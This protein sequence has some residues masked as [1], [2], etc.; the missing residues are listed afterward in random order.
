MFESGDGIAV[1]VILESKCDFILI[2]QITEFLKIEN[3]EAVIMV[4]VRQFLFL[5][6]LSIFRM[7]RIV[8]FVSFFGK[9]HRIIHFLAI[10]FGDS[11][12]EI[13]LNN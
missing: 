12:I 3:F 11:N 4:K 1:N 8:K 9:I 7:K 2:F 6:F 13:T 5:N 10:H